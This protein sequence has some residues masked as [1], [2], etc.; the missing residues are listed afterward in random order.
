MLTN[1]SLA[2]VLQVLSIGTAATI[3]PMV[4]TSPA[5][6]ATLPVACSETA[7]RNAINTANSTPGSDTLNLAPGCT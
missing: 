4:L 3:T 5:S 2:R 6:A 1:K 7:L